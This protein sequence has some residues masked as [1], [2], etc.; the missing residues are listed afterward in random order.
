MLQEGIIMFAI[1]YH[2]LALVILQIHPMAY[3][4]EV[5]SGKIILPA[6]V[7]QGKSLLSPPSA[8]VLKDVSNQGQIPF[9]NLNPGFNIAIHLLGVK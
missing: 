2:E 4:I 8:S 1:H 9:I 5:F 7:I 3:L 6:E